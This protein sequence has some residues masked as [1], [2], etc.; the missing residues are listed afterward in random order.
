MLLE[1]SFDWGVSA[2]C[3]KEELGAPQCSQQSPLRYEE[4]DEKWKI[5]EKI[6]CYIGQKYFWGNFNIGISSMLK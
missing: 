5:E 3:E 6:F 4:D 2:V 1:E